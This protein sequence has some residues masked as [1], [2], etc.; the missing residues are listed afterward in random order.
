MVRPLV[1]ASQ[2]EKETACRL[3]LQPW[4]EIFGGVPISHRKIRCKGRTDLPYDIFNKL[5]FLI[6]CWFTVYIYPHV[7]DTVLVTVACEAEVRNNP[8]KF[9]YLYYCAD[10]LCW[11]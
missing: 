8:D 3:A 6:F 10:I 2:G 11:H 4:N 7:Q 5:C 1:G 9:E